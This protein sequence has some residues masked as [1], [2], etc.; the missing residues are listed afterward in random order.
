MKILLYNNKAYSARRS[1]ILKIRQSE[2]GPELCGLW[3]PTIPHPAG[4]IGGGPVG[5]SGTGSCWG[6]GMPPSLTIWCGA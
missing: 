2:R 3:E 5:A 4:S 6:S 1:L